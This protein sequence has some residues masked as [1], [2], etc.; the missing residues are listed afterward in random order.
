[1][2]LKRATIGL[3]RGPK[4]GARV[5]SRELT[6]TWGTQGANQRAA[7]R[8]LA[9]L[10]LVRPVRAIGLFSQRFQV[11]RMHALSFANS[12]L[13]TKYWA[14]LGFSTFGFFLSIFSNY[15]GLI[16]ENSVAARRLCKLRC[17]APGS[18]S[19]AQT[20]T[21]LFGTRDLLNKDAFEL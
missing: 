13:S 10:P 11:L 1:M 4:I 15:C 9:F 5:S 6:S 16:V 20:P 12:V 18:A 8:G 2:L 14:C 3:P 21:A 7:E 17:G 19:N